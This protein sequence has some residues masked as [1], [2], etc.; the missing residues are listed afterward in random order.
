MGAKYTSLVVAIGTTATGNLTTRLC[1]NAIGV[2]GIDDGGELNG[3]E[4]P[5]ATAM[6]VN[7]FGLSS[8]A[9]DAGIFG[10]SCILIAVNLALVDERVTR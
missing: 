9:I 4:K 8:V 1:L 3:D 2:G 5:S 10:D 7:A 6:G